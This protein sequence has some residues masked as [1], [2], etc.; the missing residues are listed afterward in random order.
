MNERKRNE[1]N[2]GMVIGLVVVVAGILLLLDR[3]GFGWELGIDFGTYWPVLLII[4]G[5]GQITLV[6]RFTQG[7]FPGFMPMLPGGIMLL[8][9]T[10]FLL[11]NLGIIHFSLGDLWPVAVIL[12][13][14]FII[15]GSFGHSRVMSPDGKCRATVHA[16]WQNG[17]GK[18]G[19]KN[20]NLSGDQLDLSTIFGGGEYTVSSKDFKGGKIDVVFGGIEVD[21]RDAE[22]QGDSAVVVASAVFGSVEMRVPSRWEVVVQGTP[23]LASIE[24]KTVTPGEVSKRLVVKASVVFGSIEVRN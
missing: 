7:Q 21:L 22:I 2:F 20:G 24:N 18:H 8:L 13:G 12:V 15:R 6:G 14:L 11:R 23:V 16:T 1:F 3:I 17:H 9:G 5:L 19:S 10:Y 4:M